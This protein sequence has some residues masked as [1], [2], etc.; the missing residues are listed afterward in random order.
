MVELSVLKKRSELLNEMKNI[1][2]EIDILNK[3]LEKELHLNNDSINDKKQKFEKYSKVELL[4]RKI[5][6]KNKE[7]ESIIYEIANL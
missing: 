4:K 7:I 3:L 2:E 6:K 5:F 1:V